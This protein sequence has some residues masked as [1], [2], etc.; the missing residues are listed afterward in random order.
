MA[1]AKVAQAPSDRGGVSRRTDRMD[2]AVDFSARSLLELVAG[3]FLEGSPFS[4]LMGK[5]E[6][7]GVLFLLLNG[8]NLAVNTGAIGFINLN[9]R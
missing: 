5:K 9:V 4:F 1:S 2:A 6:R 7:R 8:V 3:L